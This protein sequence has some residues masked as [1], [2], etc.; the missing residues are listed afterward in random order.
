M[1]PA[2][3]DFSDFPNRGLD[4]PEGFEFSSIVVEVAIPAAFRAMT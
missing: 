4:V 2:D 3:V 1:K